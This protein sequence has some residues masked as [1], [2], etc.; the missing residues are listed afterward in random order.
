MAIGD[1]VIGNNITR[2]IMDALVVAIDDTN[3]TI[4]P[5]YGDEIEP[6]EYV[7]TDIDVIKIFVQ[8]L[9]VDTFDDLMRDTGGI[10][11][12]GTVNLWLFASNGAQAV[13]ATCKM[14]YDFGY[15]TEFNT[16][17]IPPGAPWEIGN[18]TVWRWNPI[19]GL[20]LTAESYGDTYLMRQTI[21]FALKYD[22]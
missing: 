5:H 10:I 11:Q 9:N 7:I 3:Y 22:E 1:N 4:K 6:E 21:D 13:D 20:N 19:G 2:R 12:E 16:I 8:V 14:F 17:G 18:L 15:V